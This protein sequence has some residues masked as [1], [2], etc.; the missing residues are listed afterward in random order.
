MSNIIEKF[1]S[2]F[3]KSSKELDKLGDNLYEFLDSFKDQIYLAYLIRYQMMCE[4]MKEVIAL[5]TSDSNN[6]P[7]SSNLDWYKEGI[8]DVVACVLYALQ[9]D[10]C[11]KYKKFC[12]TR[13]NFFEFKS[14]FYDC[15]KWS[16]YK[17]NNACFEAAMSIV[18]YIDNENNINNQIFVKLSDIVFN[19][20]SAYNSG[21]KEMQQNILK[22]SKTRLLK[23]METIHGIIDSFN[24]EVKYLIN[25]TARIIVRDI[26]NVMDPANRRVN[27]TDQVPPDANHEF[28]YDR[29][30]AIVVRSL[31]NFDKELEEKMISISQRGRYT[32]VE[33]ITNFD[34]LM[35]C[36]KGRLVKLRRKSSICMAKEI[37]NFLASENI[38]SIS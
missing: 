34:D 28:F 1:N 14:R 12:D 22:K 17:L 24:E 25:E 3:L 10:Y 5:D 23:L 35:K 27:T 11:I 16:E 6:T 20:M 19:S 2:E 38:Q 33:Y 9:N 18:D 13:F 21:I 8:F 26:T 30:F 37:T 36:A 7:F 32:I 29:F 15:H 31:R 4:P